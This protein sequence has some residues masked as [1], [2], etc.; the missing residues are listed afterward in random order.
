MNVRL[1]DVNV[2]ARDG[3]LFT[4]EQVYLRGSQVRFIIIPNMLRNAPMFKRFTSQTK[5]AKGAAAPRQKGRGA[6]RGKGPNKK[7]GPKGA[8]P[9]EGAPAK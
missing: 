4:L 6:G 5:K 3:K 1:D 8:A 9:A 2:T 7:G